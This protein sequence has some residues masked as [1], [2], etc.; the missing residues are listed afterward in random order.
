[1]SIDSELKDELNDQMHDCVEKRSTNNNNVSDGDPFD[2][3]DIVDDGNDDD[4]DFDNDPKEDN[5]DDHK[6]SEENTV[7]EEEVCVYNY[8]IHGPESSHRWIK[9]FGNPKN[10]QYKP[11]YIPP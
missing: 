2:P 8:P 1:V 6:D 10:P 3:Y 7:Q 9:C 11:N 5:N 4:N